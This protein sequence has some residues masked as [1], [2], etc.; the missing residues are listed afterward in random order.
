MSDS[1]IGQLM[2]V[3][4][5]FAPEG[6]AFCHGQLLPIAENDALFNLIRTAYGG[7]GVSTFGVPDLRGR[8]TIGAGQGPG[9]ANYAMGQKGGVETVTLTPNQ[10]PSHMHALSA[11]KGG[12]TSPFPAGNA[13]ALSVANV[14]HPGAP[15]AASM[16]ASACGPMGGGQTHNNMQPYMVL[17][18]IISL[19]GVFPRAQ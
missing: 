17:S 6:W 9:L 13:P 11:S 2:L 3:P 18:W 19:S 1:F 4:F 10:L 8:T 14:F 5:E 12:A 16:S 15:S 7:D